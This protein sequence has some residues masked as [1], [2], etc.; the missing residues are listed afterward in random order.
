MIEVPYNKNG[1][2]DT[3]SLKELLD[4]NTA[5]VVVQ[6]PNFFGLVE[7]ILEVKNILK[8]TSI[9]L[10]VVLNPL[11]L[12][13]LKKPSE[14]GADIVCADG[15]SLGGNMGFG[16][17]TFGIIA[18]KKEYLRQLPGRI[19]GKT[20]DLDGKESFCLTLQAREQHI[21]R[22]NATSNICSNQSLNAIAA[23]VYLSL[24]GKE[25]LYKAALYSLNSTH[26][27][28]NEMRKIKGITF[29]FS[30][31]FFNEFV[32]HIGSGEKALKK[33]ARQG[34]LAGIELRRFYPKLSG[35][36]LSC[37]TE[38]KTKQDID[39]FIT[40]LKDITHG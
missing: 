7:N 15:Q 13:I 18:A 14:Y 32:W 23:A 21:R 16:G 9:K 19:V 6:N 29:P 40:A 34:I 37:C 24:M 17:P 28:Y 10:I 11:S 36:I 33:L 38:K 35:C 3:A 4:S 1:L 12:A 39:S 5:S 26:Y 27:L 30:D 8:D 2:L 20:R 22:Q 31:I 25:G